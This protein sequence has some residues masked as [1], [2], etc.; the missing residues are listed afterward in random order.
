MARVRYTHQARTD[1]IDIWIHIATDS[2]AT[3]DRCLERIE[4]R[5]RDLA[6]FPALGPERPD[7]APDARMLVIDRWLA[8][9]RI[10]DD[11]VRIVR[12]VDGARDL[13]R[14]SIRERR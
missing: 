1:L 3:A 4:S 13:T 8:L 7:I 11:N 12:V 5:C 9:Y 2:Q 6:D 14:I 10:E